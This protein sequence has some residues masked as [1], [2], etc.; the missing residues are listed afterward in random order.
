MCSSVVCCTAS[1]VSKARAAHAGWCRAISALTQFSRKRAMP[2][3][4]NTATPLLALALSVTGNAQTRK[5]KKLIPPKLLL[6]AR[7]QVPVG[8]KYTVKETSPFPRKQLRYQRGRSRVVSGNVYRDRSPAGNGV[9][10]RPGNRFISWLGRV[11][12][13]FFSPNIY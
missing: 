10:S 2:D 11:I 1:F 9:G 12:C 6:M 4:E 13:H 3:K 5:E 7:L 8:S